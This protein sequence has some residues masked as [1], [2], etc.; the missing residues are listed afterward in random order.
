MRMRHAIILAGVLALATVALVP[1]Q[2]QR[3]GGAGAGGGRAEQLGLLV[4]LAGSEV[5]ARARDRVV[6]RSF[7]ARH[8]VALRTGRRDRP[9]TSESHS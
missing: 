1:M 9:V 5:A 8:T 4:R 2:A 3:Q 6:D 7:H